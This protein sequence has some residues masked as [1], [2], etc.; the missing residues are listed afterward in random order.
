MAAA[1]VDGVFVVVVDAG[2]VPVAVD[3]AGRP[4][5]PE[6]RVVDGAD[7]R[8]KSDDPAGEVALVVVV[9]VEMRRPDLSDGPGE[10]GV[11]VDWTTWTGP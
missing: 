3:G 2:M 5:A 9:L 6:A 8:G 4:A 7:V 1:V 10:L 11:E